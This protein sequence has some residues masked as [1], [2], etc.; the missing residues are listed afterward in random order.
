MPRPT[1]AAEIPSAVER[2]IK[3]LPAYGRRAR[4]LGCG[5]ATFDQPTNDL[6]K[7]RTGSTDG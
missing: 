2:T 7:R 6:A 5:P 1:I 3:P 4:R